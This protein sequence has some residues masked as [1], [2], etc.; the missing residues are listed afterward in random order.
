MNPRHKKNVWTPCY[1]QWVTLSP[2]AAYYCVK[3]LPVFIII[4]NFLFIYLLSLI[5]NLSSNTM[6]NQW[7]QVFDF[8]LIITPFLQ[9][10]KQ[11]LLYHIFW[12]NML[13]AIHCNG[14]VLITEYIL[15]S[16]WIYFFLCKNYLP[17]IHSLP[18]THE[19]LCQVLQD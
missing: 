18:V 8:A 6:E 7:K 11:C 5:F 1:K 12:I 9:C 14:E 19:A 17:N 16:G 3:F 4:R 2:I 13:N 15:C 10:K